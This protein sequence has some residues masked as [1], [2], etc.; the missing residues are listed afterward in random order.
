M[1]GLGYWRIAAAYRLFDGAGLV[2]RRSCVEG[3]VVAAARASSPGQ[4]ARASSVNA[5]D[6]RSAAGIS[7]PIS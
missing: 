5:V 4:T 6:T 3:S 1:A 7:T 2:A